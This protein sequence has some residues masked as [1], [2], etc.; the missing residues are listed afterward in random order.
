MLFFF[1][2]KTLDRIAHSA[3]V[4]LLSLFSSDSLKLDSSLQRT[5]PLLKNLL[6]VHFRFGS[7]F[8]FSSDSLKL[9][10]ILQR[11]R[12]ILKPINLSAASTLVQVFSSSTGLSI[13]ASGLNSLRDRIPFDPMYF[14]FFFFFFFVNEFILPFFF[15]FLCVCVNEDFMIYKSSIVSLY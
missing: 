3:L 6:I 10:S 8:L 5:R 14:F 15:F 11:T 7:S 4:L 1:R 13:S 9:D 2:R 12:P